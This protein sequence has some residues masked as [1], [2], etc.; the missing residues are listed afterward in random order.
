MIVQ[1]AIRRVARLLDL[2]TQFSPYKS[3]EEKWNLPLYEKV[4]SAEAVRER[5]FYNIG[6]GGFFHPAW[7]NVDHKS[8]YYARFDGYSKGGMEYDLMALVRLDLPDNSAELFYSSHTVEHVSDAAAQNLFNEAHRV[9]KKGG[10]FRC[11][12]P[13]IDLG[14]RAFL[15]KDLNYFYWIDDFSVPGL[16]RKL[17]YDRPLN[18][19]SLEQIFLTYFAT[20]TSI[21]HLDGSPE[22]L[23]DENVRELFSTMEREAALEFI[24]SKCSLE[25]QKKYPGNHINWWNKDKM[26]RMFSAAGFSNIW[27]S[28]YGQSI[29]PVLRDTNFFDLRHP[30][31]SLYVE[32]RK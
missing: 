21:I 24:T 10:V 9:L 4:Y 2:E 12:T 6:A 22:R 30:A 15:E 29:S 13:N 5:R 31:I 18:Q 16:Y 32:A 8:D 14:L 11:T 1:K 17:P 26:F 27:L 7:T 3:N 25:V 20:S 28:G 19:A 23:T